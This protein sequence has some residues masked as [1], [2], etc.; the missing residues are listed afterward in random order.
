M[1][2]DPKEVQPH[3]GLEIDILLFDRLLGFTPLLL[4]FSPLYGENLLA[5]IVVELLRELRAVAKLE[6]DFEV[7]EERSKNQCYGA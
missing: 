6:Q 1:Y 3:H 5:D 4:S 2:H 7:H